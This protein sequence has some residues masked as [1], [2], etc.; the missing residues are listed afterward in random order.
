MLQERA[1]SL[2]SHLQKEAV[3]KKKA[4]TDRDTPSESIYLKGSAYFCRAVMTVNMWR[5][6]SRF[7]QCVVAE[8][9]YC[10]QDLESIS[11]PFSCSFESKNNRWQIE[12]VGDV[13]G[14][15]CFLAL[16]GQG[17]SM[18][19]FWSGEPFWMP[20]RSELSDGA[21]WWATDENKESALIQSSPAFPPKT[22]RM[23]AWPPAPCSLLPFSLSPAAGQ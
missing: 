13:E 2:V 23:K 21:V 14:R 10:Q 3:R 16:I 1:S 19:M 17:G 7:W 8:G 15:Q 12:G 20:L 6:F 4:Q 11:V 18:W 9:L 5:S 22:N